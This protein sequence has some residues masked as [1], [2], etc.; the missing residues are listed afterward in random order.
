MLRED[1]HMGRQQGINRVVIGV[2]DLDAGMGFYSELLQTTFVESVGG[3]AASFG[4]RVAMNFDAGVE[5]VAPLPGR[6]SQLRLTME[7]RGEGVVGVVFAVPDADASRQAATSHGIGTYHS[8]DYSQ[9]EIDER[10]GPNRFTRFYEHF[11]EAVPPLSGITLVG[12]FD[13]PA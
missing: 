11:L 4:V 9:A 8:L 7:E 1:R 6:E 5:L 2:W 3:E 12:E 10:H 13:E